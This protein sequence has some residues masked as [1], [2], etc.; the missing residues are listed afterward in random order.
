MNEMVVLGETRGNHGF[1]QKKHGSPADSAPMQQNRDAIG[2]MMQIC[3][4]LQKK[5]VQL[6]LTI[7]A[8]P[9]AFSN[10]QHQIN[11]YIYII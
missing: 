2:H 5:I 4:V 6:L 1:P 8:A 7:S 11:T 3:T 9:Y 10:C